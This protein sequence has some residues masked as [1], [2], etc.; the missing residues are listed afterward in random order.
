MDFDPQRTVRAARTALSHRRRATIAM[1][2]TSSWGIG[3]F[4]ALFFDASVAFERRQWFSFG[5]AVF[6]A[7]VTLWAFATMGR[8]FYLWLRITQ[9]D[10]EKHQRTIQ[11]LADDGEQGASS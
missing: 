9:N 5:A 1:L 10:A 6:F 8:M 4:G 2:V 7:T 11:Q 3:M